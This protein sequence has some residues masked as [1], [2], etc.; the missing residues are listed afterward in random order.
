[1]VADLSFPE[2]SYTSVCFISFLGV[3]CLL[4]ACSVTSLVLSQSGSR[5][6]PGVPMCCF[7]Q[8]MM[9]AAFAKMKEWWEGP[10]CCLVPS[11]YFSKKDW[12]IRQGYST[13]GRY[14]EEIRL[15]CVGSG[16]LL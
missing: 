3:C 1:M 12:I 9:Y 14:G 11:G 15:S 16:L 10:C 4:T 2:V 8:L 6:T 5:L 7:G 13:M